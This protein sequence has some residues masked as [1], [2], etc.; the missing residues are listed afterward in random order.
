MD[1]TKIKLWHLLGIIFSAVLVAAL[2][3]HFLHVAVGLSRREIL[4]GALIAA[5]VSIFLTVLIVRR[6]HRR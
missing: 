1:P 5:T 3:R 2:L 6:R 4:A